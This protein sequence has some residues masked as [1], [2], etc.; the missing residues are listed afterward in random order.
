M[1]RSMLVAAVVTG[2]CTIVGA[3]IT[4]SPEAANPPNSHKTGGFAPPASSLLHPE[5]IAP[6]DGHH[7]TSTKLDITVNAPSAQ[8]GHQWYLAVQPLRQ[9]DS[10]YFFKA[11]PT[12]GTHYVAVVDTGPKGTTGVGRY[13]I[14]LVDADDSA[15]AAISRETTDYLPHYNKHGMPLPAGAVRVHSIKIIRTG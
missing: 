14:S 7:T 15:K 3:I 2:V 1:S 13:V 8:R 5:I 12:G 4:T 6:G 9:P 11:V 10:Y